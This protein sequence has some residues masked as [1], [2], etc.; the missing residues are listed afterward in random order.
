ML[1]FSVYSPSRAQEVYETS[2][3]A[4]ANG[5]DWVM[6]NILPQ[7]AGL[8]VNGVVYRYTTVKETEDDMVVHVQNEDALN[9][10]QYIFR[11]TDDW[12]GLPGNT[13]R[14]LVPVNNIPR[15][16][17][18]D[19]SIQI[20]GKGSVENALVLYNYQYDPCFGVTDK[21]ECPNYIPPIVMPDL[22]MQDPL[23]DPYIKE[24]LEKKTEVEDEDED[25]RDRKRTQENGKVRERRS[26]ESILGIVEVSLVA[27]ADVANMTL[28]TNLNTIPNSYYVILP[29]TKYEETIV[30]PDATLPDNTR[31][32]RVNFAQDQLH[33]R[34]VN[35]QYEQ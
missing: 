5:L 19:G 2:P 17:W 22:A 11:S 18:G 33:Q 12:S 6:S 32:A 29:D 4:A 8:T 10:G 1:C 34:M 15:E 21:P 27:A 24:E 7:Q 14:K 35:L 13:I 23:D 20:E 25:E 3:N 30:L 26:L 28:L 9:L 16:R 31:A